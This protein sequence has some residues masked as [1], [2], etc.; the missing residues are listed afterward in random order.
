LQEINEDK[1]VKCFQMPNDIISATLQ[2]NFDLKGKENEAVQYLALLQRDGLLI[3]ANFLYLA[4]SFEEFG[5]L[6]F[7]SETKIENILPSFD[8]THLVS[9]RPQ[10]LRNFEG[11]N[12]LGVIG[13][14]TLLYN[15]Y[16]EKF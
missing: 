16:D 3:F 11:K 2:R 15:F 7:V 4:H 13:S 5:E 8:N 10:G 1:K 12:F 9:L 14:E 6:A